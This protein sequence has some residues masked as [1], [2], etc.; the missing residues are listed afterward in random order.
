MEYEDFINAVALRARV[1]TDQAATLTRVTLENLGDRI[2]AGQAEDLAYQL[3][4]GLDDH[5]RRPRRWEHATSY[6]LEEF[7]QRVGDRPDV[8]RALAGA[9]VRAVLTTLREAVTRDQFEDTVAQLPNEFRQVI[10]PVGAGGGRPPGPYS[11]HR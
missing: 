7:V 4:D 3:P 5:L 6:G 2:S 10:E 1:S 9:G 11:P 8:D